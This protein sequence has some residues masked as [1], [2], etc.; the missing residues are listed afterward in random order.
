MGSRFLKIKIDPLQ[1]MTTDQYIT[2]LGTKFTFGF[3]QRMKAQEMTY[4]IFILD[5]P[6]YG[7]RPDDPHTTHRILE[8][9]DRLVCWTG[10]MP[11][12][13]VAKNVAGLWADFTERYILTGQGFPGN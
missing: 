6:D 4:V 12:I 3:E 9:D 13:S 8:G 10:L 5:Q 7:G 1:I 2:K 11:N